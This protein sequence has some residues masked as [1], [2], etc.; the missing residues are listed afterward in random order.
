MLLFRVLPLTCSKS[1]VN[2]RTK[3]DLVG[4]AKLTND[5]AIIDSSHL[6]TRFL[7]STWRPKAYFATYSVTD[8]MRKRVLRQNLRARCQT[9]RRIQLP[10][11]LTS[12]RRI[13]RSHLPKTTLSL[14]SPTR[15][16]PIAKRARDRPFLRTSQ[17]KA[18][19]TT[20]NP[21]AAKLLLHSNTTLYEARIATHAHLDSIDAT[22]GLLDALDGF[23]ATI[24]V[25]KAEFKGRKEMC[26]E[27]MT[28]LED[29][30]R[31]VE[32]M[33]FAEED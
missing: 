14:H 33:R 9:S 1:R 19:A 15:Y 23:S 18:S 11:P 25:L 22:L 5:L 27:K 20:T 4:V 3:N 8:L 2:A 32:H 21:P 10:R 16:G 17:K 12:P 6:S 7:L 29:I 30:E 13:E 31:V 28:M 24:T 26:E